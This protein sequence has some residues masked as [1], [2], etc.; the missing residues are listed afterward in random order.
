DCW[1]MAS[2]AEVADRNPT[3]IRNMFID[4]G[5]GTFTVRFYHNGMSDYVTVDKYLPN[6]GRLYDHPQSDLWVAL[7]EKAYAQEY[8]E[9]W[10]GSGHQGVSSYQALSGGYPAWALPAI[11]GMSTSST[12]IYNILGL[13]NAGAIA[14]AWSQG[15]FV[16]LCTDSPSSSL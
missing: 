9:G 11:T 12:T 10:I 2:L 4:N 16:V 1:L 6:G 14:T 3:I 13:T 8:A 7:A 15:Q 5:D